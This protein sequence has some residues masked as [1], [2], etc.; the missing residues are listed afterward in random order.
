MQPHFPDHVLVAASHPNPYPYYAELR[1]GPPLLWD[2]ERSLWIA[3]TAAAVAGVLAH[4]ASRVR[5]LREPVPVSIVG[6]PAGEVFGHLVRMN[7]GAAHASP[8][9]S[10]ERALA[11]VPS[12]TVQACAQQQASHVPLVHDTAAELATSL[13]RACF[14]VPVRTVAQC[15]GFAPQDLPQVAQWLGDFVACLSPLSTATQLQAASA[16]AQG[17]LERV[18][19][20]V[21][22]SATP[23]AQQDSTQFI[24]LVQR[25]Q[26]HV[27]DAGWSSKQALLCNLV[28]LMSQTY[29]ASAGLL[30]N[31]VA[32]LAREPQLWEYLQPTMQTDAWPTAVRHV[33]NAV[34][35][36]DA[37]IQTTRRWLAEDA[38]I[39]GADLPACAAVVLLLGSANRDASVFAKP[40]AV[41]PS[42]EDQSYFSFGRGL[43]VCPGR[44][45]AI[46]VVSATL[47]QWLQQWP[48]SGNGIDLLGLNDL[49]W[50][51]RPSANARLPVFGATATH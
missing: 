4:P 35:R 12:Q 34:C 20:L 33:V 48:R 39:L 47:A 32:A 7:D 44:T 6:S 15:M 16:A 50:S 38:H 43:H 2:A 17:L 29:E 10:L 5:P 3:S 45:L 25:V 1:A 49:C 28:G 23:N 51:Y 22:R 30:G 26:A 13:N 31:T 27:A 36:W 14:A 24:T 46:D 37:P 42:G 8:K 21:A 18:E 19:E 40:D 9:L 11:E 41:L